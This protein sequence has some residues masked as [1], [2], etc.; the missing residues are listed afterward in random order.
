MKLNTTSLKSVRNFLVRKKYITIGIFII[1]E[2]DSILVEIL[3]L[4]L[5]SRGEKDLE[6]GERIP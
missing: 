4:D 6:I 2:S 3:N 1:P 5:F